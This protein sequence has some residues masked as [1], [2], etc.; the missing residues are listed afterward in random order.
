M[1]VEIIASVVSAGFI[2]GNSGISGISGISV[3]AFSAPSISI[4]SDLSV[5][6]FLF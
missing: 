6:L 2:S 4:T 1:P 5:A 3:T